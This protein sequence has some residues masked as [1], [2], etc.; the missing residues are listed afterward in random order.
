MD[1]NHAVLALPCVLRVITRSSPQNASYNS[2][3]PVFLSVG[4][5]QFMIVLQPR[6]I[7]RHDRAMFHHQHHDWK[8]AIGRDD[9]DS[10]N[11]SYFSSMPINS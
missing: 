5:T 4:E 3:N 2:E 10:L 6:G 9:A 11:D 7:Q 1:L 8:M